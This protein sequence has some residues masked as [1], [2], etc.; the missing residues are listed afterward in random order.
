MQ[1]R[2]RSALQAHGR[3]SPTKQIEMRRKWRFEAC[4]VY[5]NWLTF[6]RRRKSIVCSIPDIPTPGETGNYADR[7]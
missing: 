5:E 6:V 7:S 2:A 4:R 3:L 1:K